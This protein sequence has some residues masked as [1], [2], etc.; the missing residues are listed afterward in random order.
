M[1]TSS[2]IVAVSMIAFVCAL[3]APAVQAKPTMNAQGTLEWLAID[4][5]LDKMSGNNTFM[6]GTSTLAFTGTL[7][8]PAT[9]VWTEIFHSNFNTFRDVITVSCTIDDK[10]GTLVIRVVGS[11][12]GPDF[13]WSGH[14]TIL[15][16]TG[17][18]ANLCG[19]GTWSG[20]VVDLTYS[21]TIG[22]D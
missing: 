14:W 9:D 19:G 18:L 7:A 17:E 10:S 5:N 21:G 22:F 4:W 1:R 16:G 12:A 2:A 3:S 13:I 11:A 15:Y 20:P 8:G 6:V